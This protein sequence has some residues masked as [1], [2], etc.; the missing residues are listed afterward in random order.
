MAVFYRGLSPTELEAFTRPII[1][2]K[3]VAEGISALVLDVKFGAGPLPHPKPLP[4]WRT[5][6][7]PARRW[8][9]LGRSPSGREA[10]QR[11]GSRCWPGQ[12]SAFRSNNR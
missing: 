9:V 4:G 10:I 7:I 3:E 5:C 12:V 1:A 11:W 6:S 8:I 2:S